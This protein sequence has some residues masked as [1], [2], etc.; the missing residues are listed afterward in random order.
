MSC[1][2]SE[3]PSEDIETNDACCPSKFCHDGLLALPETNRLQI[4]GTA[5]GSK[6]LSTFPRYKKGFVVQDGAGG[7][8]VTMQP[9]VAIP[10]LRTLLYDESGR[11]LIS[12]KGCQLEGDPPN[13]DS[14]VVSGECG[15]QWRLRGK[16]DRVQKPQ[17]NGCRWELVD[18]EWQKDLDSFPPIRDGRD[19]CDG[20]YPMV[21]IMNANGTVSMGYRE[22]SYLM[23]GEVKMFG[24]GPLDLEADWLYCDGSDYAPAQYPKLYAKIGYRWGQV[25]DNFRVPDMRGFFPRGF[26]DSEGNDP[27]AAT[28]YA[29]YSGGADGDNVGSYQHDAFQCHTHDIPISSGAGS[30][31]LLTQTG[32]K[33]LASEGSETTGVEQDADCGTVRTASETR[34]KNAAFVF[35]IYAG[36]E[37]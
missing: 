19:E 1:C 20:V 29:L 27:D 23:P 26:D 17:W 10:Y 4:T 16:S 31:T 25:G 2:D 15:L 33:L 28:R 5:R 24:C 21:L 32:S 7:A 35:A 14:F 12:D 6:C 22:K 37:K 36:C 30:S 13:F 11:P 34:P 8:R 3:T 18:D 9:N